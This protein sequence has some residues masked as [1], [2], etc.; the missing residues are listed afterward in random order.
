MNNIPKI[1][2]I[3]VVFN[4]EKFIEATIKS[5]LNQTF[6][7][8]EYIIIDG[9]SKDKTV[10]IIKAYEDKISNWISEPDKGLY[11]A[12]N[13]GVL[14][15]KG[16]YILFINSGDKLFNDTT[17]EDIF[18]LPEADVYYG[19]TL[20]INTEDKELGVR[21]LRPPEKL[22]FK[23]FRKG[24]LVCHQS[25][26]AKKSLVPS[27]DLKYKYASDYDWTIEILRK[28]D[29]II[30]TH[31]TISR[32][33]EGGQTSKKVYKGLAE[34]FLIMKKHYG[35]FSAIMLNLI[36]IPRFI[37]YLFTKRI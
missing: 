11:D 19:D 16:E 2:I 1:S 34:R 36:L 35:L 5:I 26:I 28:S 33:L 14:R 8:V 13:K 6:K 12:M 3:T 22:N 17:L 21:R 9:N 15:A 4:S 37:G 29:T 25:F 32:F 23:S 24:M 7:N 20:I 30:N 27:F 18:N 10:D 31:L